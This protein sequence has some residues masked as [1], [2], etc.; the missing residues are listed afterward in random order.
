MKISSFIHFAGFGLKTILLRKKEPILGTVIVTDKCNLKCRHCSVN[1][2][3]A[4]GHPYEQIRREMQL[5][6]NMG[7]RILFF[8]GGETFLWR[9]GTH[10]LRTLVADAKE[11]GFLLVNVVTNGTYPIDLPEADLILLSLDGDKDR[12]N[13]IR[14]DTYDT[15]MENIENASSDNIC[16]Y[17]AVNQINKDTVRDVCIATRDTKN[18]RAVSFNF[19]TPYPDTKNLALSKEEKAECCRVISKMIKECV[20]VFNLRSAFP[21]LINNSFPTPCYQCVVIENGKLSTCGRCIEIPGLCKECGYFFVAEYTLLFRGNPRI[22]LEMLMT[23]LK[24]I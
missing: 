15:I 20:P 17:M 22:I 23:Y 24:Y 1:T 18:V 7:V 10:T 13:A 8:C 4:V 3:T 14:G 16:F 2:I 11:M 5:L 19:H 12:H 6:Y 9:D 21:Y